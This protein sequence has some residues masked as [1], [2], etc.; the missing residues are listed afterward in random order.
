MQR[1]GEKLY[2]LR[3]QQGLTQMQLAELLGIKYSH[4]GKMERG[5]RLPSL[6]VL[7]KLMEIFNVS[8]DQLLMDDREL[9]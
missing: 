3:K 7:A 9:E 4:V 6:E 5:Q 2:T 8:C 1:L